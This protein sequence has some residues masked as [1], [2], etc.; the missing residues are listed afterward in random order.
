MQSLGRARRVPVRRVAYGDSRSFTEQAAV[1]LSC[2]AT[3]PPVVATTFAS[4]G[5]GSPRSAE[6]AG[7]GPFWAVPRGSE[8]FGYVNL[9]HGLRALSA[10]SH[11]AG[12][13][14]PLLIRGN[15]VS[16]RD[17]VHRPVLP[18]IICVCR[19]VLADLA[20]GGVR[21]ICLVGHHP[22]LHAKEPTSIGHTRGW[23]S[24]AI[25][26]TTSSGANRR[27]RTGE[28]Q[29]CSRRR[30]ATGLR[31]TDSN[32]D[33]N[34]GRQPLSLTHDSIQPR[35]DLI[36]R[37]GRPLR[38]ISG[39]SASPYHAPRRVEQRAG[40]GPIQQQSTATPPDSNEHELPPTPCVSWDSGQTPSSASSSGRRGR[41]FKSGHPDRETAGHR[42]SS[43]LL[44]VLQILG[45][46][47]LG[48]RWERTQVTVV[49]RSAPG[50]FA[51]SRQ[52]ST[53]SRAHLWAPRRTAQ[54]RAG[55]PRIVRA[56]PS[57]LIGAASPGVER[58]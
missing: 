58:R 19:D 31:L 26:I 33:S 25:T 15:P 39:R 50:S 41:R 13:A 11:V 36:T 47:I 28:A 57:S 22:S 27:T 30:D 21:V 18:L 43:G 10:P 12:E 34:V 9:R 1:L 54:V 5:S 17:R 46:P 49:V 2:A 44:F 51:E 52:L 24:T 38:L 16:G 29:V 23:S 55:T 56:S 35:L 53:T 37:T 20:R 8:L 48:A 45:C 7:R 14:R 3:A 32:G 42:A 6:V 4:R 40:G